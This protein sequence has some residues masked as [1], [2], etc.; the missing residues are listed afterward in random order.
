MIDTKK[1]YERLI[2][3]FTQQQADLLTDVM[4]EQAEEKLATV[5]ARLN[6]VDGRLDGIVR[7]VADIKSELWWLRWGVCAVLVA[8]LS[9]WFKR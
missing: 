4:K 6:R 1:L 5:D 8:V 2:A 3:G 9:L 7:D